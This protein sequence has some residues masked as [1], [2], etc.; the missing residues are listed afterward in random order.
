M[1]GASTF[2]AQQ[3]G[4]R[5]CLYTAINIYTYVYIQVRSRII[6]ISHFGA[7]QKQQKP[8]AIAHM[9]GRK[10]RR[11]VGY[12]CQS[13]PSSPSPHPNRAIPNPIPPPA[14]RHAA[15]YHN[16]A[17]ARRHPLGKVTVAR[18]QPQFVTITNQEF[19]ASA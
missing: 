9:I 13:L 12:S 16:H 3:F 11:R 19:P 15:H 14:H 8:V 6:I 5:L 4:V 7:A 1:K 2:R 10:S 17:S 18:R